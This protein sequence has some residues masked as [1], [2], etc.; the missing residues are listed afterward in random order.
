MCHEFWQSLLSEARMVS[1]ALVSATAVT[2]SFSSSCPALV[3]HPL[4]DG[5]LVAKS[6]NMTRRKALFFRGLRLYMADLDY[7]EIFKEVN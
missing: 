6:I 5:G 4:I 1:G 3:S 7:K 2:S